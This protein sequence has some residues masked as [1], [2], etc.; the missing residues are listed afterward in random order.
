LNHSVHRKSSV[1]LFVDVETL[2]GGNVSTNINVDGTLRLTKYW[3]PPETTWDRILCL[4]RQT[5]VQYFHHLH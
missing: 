5:L 3:D 4:G 1:H 2:D